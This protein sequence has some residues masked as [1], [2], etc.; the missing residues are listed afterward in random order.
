MSCIASVFCS[1]HNLRWA[2]LL[3]RAQEVALQSRESSFARLVCVLGPLGG[4]LRCCRRS[5]GLR[6][7]R[8]CCSLVILSAGANKSDEVSTLT[9]KLGLPQRR[10]VASDDDELRLAGAQRLESGFVAESDLAGLRDCQRLLEALGTRCE[11]TLIVKASLALMLSV[12]LLLFLGAIVIGVLGR[13]SRAGL[14][15]LPL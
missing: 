5:G 2:R 11:R 10:R 14:Q 4:G 7:W 1:L 13:V 8:A 3:L 6:Y 9:L 15:I 12:V